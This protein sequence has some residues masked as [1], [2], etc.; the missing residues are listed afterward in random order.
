MKN[1]QPCRADLSSQSPSARTPRKGEP[2]SFFSCL[3]VLNLHDMH[4]RLLQK[5]FLL[6]MAR[7]KLQSEVTTLELVSS[8]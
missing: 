1:L 5:P 3:N 8:Y 2:G 7:Q 4:H 6:E